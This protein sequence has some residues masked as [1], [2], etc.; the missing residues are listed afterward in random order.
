MLGGRRQ[1]G[2][3]GARIIGSF[4]VLV[5]ALAVQVEVQI[6]DVAVVGRQADGRLGRRRNRLDLRVLLEQQAV[7]DA[8]VDDDVDFALFGALAA[9]ARRPP[10]L[11]CRSE[12]RCVSTGRLNG[13]YKQINY[14]DAIVSR[15]LHDVRLGNGARDL[16]LR[17]HH[18]RMME[19]GVQQQAHYDHRLVL[20]EFVD[21]KTCPKNGVRA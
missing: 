20:A 9:R 2:R 11:R 15:M 18:Q 3:H 21:Q 10:H 4:A 1:I 19:N 8:L 16:L 14:L 6:V 17:Y 5:L 12:P 7:V 13:L